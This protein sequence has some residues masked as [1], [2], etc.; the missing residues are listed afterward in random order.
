M[1]AARAGAARDVVA[2]VQ[3]QIG[4]DAVGQSLAIAARVGDHRRAAGPGVL[5]R[6][7]QARHLRDHQVPVVVDQYAGGRLE[8]AVL[9]AGRQL[10]AGRG[11]TRHPQG[12][13]FLARAVGH[14]DIAA[15]HIGQADAAEVG[16]AG[17]DRHIGLSTGNTRQSQQGCCGGGG[18]SHHQ[19]THLRLR[20]WV[21]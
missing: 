6:E 5:S 1:R 21:V 20:E 14:G 10:G 7:A 3:E 4:E 2:K 8:V 19:S 12:G 16:H 18:R 15:G 9:G 17:A 13:D 11:V